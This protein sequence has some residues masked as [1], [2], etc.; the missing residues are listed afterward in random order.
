MKYNIENNID[1]YKELYIS[2]YEDVDKTDHVDVVA[3][4]DDNIKMCLIS[5]LPLKDYY[6]QL[7]CGHK[8]N[9]EPLYK[10]I[11]NHKKRFNS[12]EQ[13]KNKLA[14]HQIRFP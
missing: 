3:N 5:N 2:L 6:V 1:F 14:L 9:Y 8:F 13:K 12:L 4:E 10:D 7:N 11:F